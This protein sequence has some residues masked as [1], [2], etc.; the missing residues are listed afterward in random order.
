ML[1]VPV[2]LCIKARW[3]A[4]M[5]R[6]GEVLENHALVLHRGRILDLL[7][8][9][10]ADERYLPEASAERPAHLLIPG[11][12]NARASIGAAPGAP[13]APIFRSEGALLAVATLLRSGITCFC[14]VGAHPR[15]TAQL[16][17][18]QGL[19]ALIGLPVSERA[20][21][22]AADAGE[23]FTHAILLRDEFKA[24]PFIHTGFAPD[25][26]E[27]LSDATLARV[28]MLAD[29]ID[30]GIFVAL[31]ERAQDVEACVAQHG[32]R[33]LERLQRQGLLTPA[34]CA[35]HMAV[36]T[37]ADL[38]LARSGGI[39]VALCIESDLAR[40]GGVAPIGALA[41][42]GLRLG[43]GTERSLRGHDQ[44]L[45]TEIKLATLLSRAATPADPA[46]DA[47]QV[48]A[49]ASI[50]TW[51]AL[52]AATRGG[53]SALGLEADLGT[54]EPGKWADLCCIDLGGPAV[55]PVIDP[56][57]QLVFSGGRDI[58]SDV[59]VAGR[60]LLCDGEF[61]RLDWPALARRLGLPDP[62]AI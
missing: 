24:H 36:L 13:Q 41:G 28:R 17:L 58:V 46:R 30:A 61:T 56:I 19:R 48:P 31:H 62:A 29:E 60:Q 37:D 1:P 35:A 42:A 40:G 32:E 9:P 47:R 51:D 33:P 50:G 49:E 12:V 39:G 10:A 14:D 23:C 5:S 20:S 3:I 59:W 55:Q 43:L 57:G 45:W 54:L 53:A 22:W 52:A 15:S 25:R 16:V 2:D 8:S 38:E 4:P 34:L 11:L 44:D 27:Q 18:E 7:P 21:P 6:R 26:P